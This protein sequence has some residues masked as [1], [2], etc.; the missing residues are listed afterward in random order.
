M[1]NQT[2]PSPKHALKN[3]LEDTRHSVRKCF[4]VEIMKIEDVGGIK[5]KKQKVIE[6][7]QQARPSLDKAALRTIAAPFDDCAA[8]LLAQQ[9]RDIA[10][11]VDGKIADLNADNLGNKAK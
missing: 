7:A 6:A 9:L 4:D 3:L 10:D 5:A 11:E 8:S 2:I 1:K